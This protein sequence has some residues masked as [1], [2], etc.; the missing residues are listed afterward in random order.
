M[1]L[2][3]AIKTRRSVREFLPDPVRNEDVERIVDA[4][5]YAPSAGNSQPWRFLVVTDRE[6]LGKLYDRA[7]AVIERRIDDSDKLSNEEKPAATAQYRSYAEKIFA[8]PVFVFVFVETGPHPDLLDY[9][10]ALTVQNLLLAAHA[11]GYGSCVQTSLFPEELVGDH[12]GVP[13]DHRFICAVPIGKAASL[14]GDP[15][16]RPVDELVWRERFPKAEA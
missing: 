13:T 4:G 16:R 9:D 11:L 8:A 3:E 2:L 14:P 15:G 12:F 6:S 10:G 5:R 7:I 1:D